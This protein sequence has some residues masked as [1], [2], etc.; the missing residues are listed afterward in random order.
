MPALSERSSPSPVGRVGEIVILQR[1]DLRGLLSNPCHNLKKPAQP[2]LAVSSRCIAA[3]VASDLALKQCCNDYPG[4]LQGLQSRPIVPAGL[5]Q[6]GCARACERRPRIGT[7]PD[8]YRIDWHLGWGGMSVV[9]LARGRTQ[10]LPGDTRPLRGGSARFRSGRDEPGGRDHQQGR[11]RST[12][13]A[14]F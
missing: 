3:E 12:G 4:S 10:A 1:M 9:S 11:P 8:G 14:G 13:R 7:E 5:R 6:R 2:P